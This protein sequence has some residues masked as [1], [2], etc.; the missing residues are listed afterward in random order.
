[1]KTR[2]KPSLFS[3]IGTLCFL[4]SFVGVT[5]SSEAQQD[6]ATSEAQQVGVMSLERQKVPQTIS[7]PGRAVAF[8]QV[9]IRP[10]VDGVVTKILYTPGATLKVGAPLFQLDD[11]SYV[12]SV[13]SDKADLAKAEADLPV[14]QATYERALA[15][16]G[17]GYTE[18]EVESARSDFASAQATLDAAQSALDYAKTQL[19]WTTIRSPIEGVPEVSEVSVGDLVTS[20][21]SDALTTMTRLNPIYV[22]MLDTST[23]ILKMRRQIK[24]GSLQAS[25]QLDARLQLEDGEVYT[26]KGTFVAPSSTVST[27]TGTISMRFE[28]ENSDHQIL[29][30]MF[31]QGEVE[32][33][34][35]DAFLVPQRATERSSTGDLTAYI[36]DEDSKAK[37]VTFTSI[38]VYE[39]SWIVTD[40][41]ESGQKIILDGLKTMASGTLVKPVAAEIDEDG[42][43]RDV[44][45]D[46]DQSQDQAGK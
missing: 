19:S 8:E 7:L 13:A 32:V 41:L 21:Q 42:L 29:P 3:A 27:T 35:L 14:K 44:A 26:G 16:K 31:L 37:Q 10:R 45:N 20:G 36:V 24:S 30:G 23:N 5:N 40:V 17:Q 2:K 25:K 43:V 33:G 9:D 11:A 1:M 46:E 38:G 28:F 15:L 18:A 34:T 4:L 12:A 39:N 22:D 6:K